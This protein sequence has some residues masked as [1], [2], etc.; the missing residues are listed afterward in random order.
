MDY[1]SL[2][3]RLRL[4]VNRKAVDAR[5]QPILAQ[6]PQNERREVYERCLSCLD[7]TLLTPMDSAESVT[8]FARTAA[9]FNQHFP[10][11]PNV[12][13]V[14][15]WPQYVDAAGLALGESEIAIASVGGGFPASKTF[16]EVKMLECAMAQE[17]GADE[18]DIVLNL[19]LYGDKNYDAAASEIET[20]AHELGSDTRLK[21]ILESGVLP[22]LED[23]RRAAAIALAGGADMLKTSTGKQGT[24]ATPEAALVICEAIRDYFEY[25]GKRVGFKA[26]GGVRTAAEAVL[27]YTIVKEVLG[28]E[29]LTPDYFRLGASSL[30]NDLLTHIEGKEIA[31]F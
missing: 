19:G 11:L 16:L 3:D 2:I 23:V 31:Y 21:V 12:A 6:C 5:L 14:C 28:D 22:S 7:L 27:Y 15:V 9:D 10:H 17:S 20:I 13:A 24:G 26:A 30:A 25:T 4:P 1:L 29:W 8:E 18:I